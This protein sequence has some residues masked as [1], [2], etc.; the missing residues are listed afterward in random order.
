MSISDAQLPELIGMIL[1]FMLTLMVFSYLI[2]DNPLFRIAIHIFIGVAAGLA[3][4]MVFYNVLWPQLIQPLISGDRAERVYVI[5]P[6]VLGG[7]LLMRVSNR[8]GGWGRWSLAYLVGVGA[9]TAITGALLGTLFPQALATINLFDQSSAS[10]SGVDLFLYLGESGIILIGV[11][12]SLAYFHF[13]LRTR[14]G[15]VTNRGPIVEG[16]AWI[17]R[18]FIAIAL[19]ALFAGVYMA[20]ITALIERLSFIVDFLLPIFTPK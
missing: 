17:G 13:G 8:I 15:Q 9:A 7:L 12:A 2:G 4:V 6:L 3:A 5:A 10:T 19:G 11:V 20:A 16:S 14:N 1:G 18:I